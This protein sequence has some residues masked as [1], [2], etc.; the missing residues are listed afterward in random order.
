MPFAARVDS[1][2]LL[3]LFRM[4][5]FIKDVFP[6]T[7]C[8]EASRITL[9]LGEEGKATHEVLNQQALL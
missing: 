2:R 7:P 9:T 6:N 3:F 4:S 5:A 1:D 8:R